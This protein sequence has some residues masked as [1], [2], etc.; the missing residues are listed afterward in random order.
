R[1]YFSWRGNDSAAH[2]RGLAPYVSGLDADAGVR[3]S[4]TSS[5]Q[6]IWTAPAADRRS[7]GVQLVTVAVQTTAQL[8][9]LSVPVARDA[10]GFLYIA[11]YPAIVGPPATDSSA[12]PAH[13]DAVGD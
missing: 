5:Q 6:V 1:A 9:Y 3:P 8:L 10:H 12:T 7:H 11:G 13:E 4:G 2:A